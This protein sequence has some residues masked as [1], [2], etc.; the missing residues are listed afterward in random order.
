MTGKI[1]GHGVD[2]NRVG[3][4]GR[5]T[6]ERYEWPI[7]LAWDKSED[8]EEDILEANILIKHRRVH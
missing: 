5:D 7:P 2:E 8:G 1:W 4:R 3:V 6:W